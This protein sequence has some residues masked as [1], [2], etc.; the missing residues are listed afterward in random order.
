[1]SARLP[2]LA[3][4]AA[5]LL[6]PGLAVAQEK[7]ASTPAPA[8]NAL[9][10]QPLGVLNPT[11]QQRI[12][13]ER[14]PAARRLSP[15]QL[16]ALEHKRP[17]PSFA[18][19]RPQ[20]RKPAPGEGPDDVKQPADKLPVQAGAA[21]AAP[22]LNG[23]LADKQPA[24]AAAK[25]A[26]APAAAKAE[27]DAKTADAQPAEAK[28]A[29]AKSKVVKKT[30]R[31]TIATAAQPATSGITEIIVR[32]ATPTQL[33]ERAAI[34]YRDLRRRDLEL[35]RHLLPPSQYE[36]KLAAIEASYRP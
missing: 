15:S 7:A 28:P 3:L 27:G 17:P 21:A 31:T 35:V 25:P 33:F 23:F 22:S 29:P 19:V 18:T 8:P 26:A 6:A 13:E 30:T 34:Q 32:P 2:L 12:Q 11:T 24:K 10:V 20:M 9:P 4:V 16:Y 14:R 36:A 5:A 1:M